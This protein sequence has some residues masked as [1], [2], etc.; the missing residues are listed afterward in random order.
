MPRIVLIKGKLD[1]K[2]IARSFNSLIRSNYEDLVISS[3]FSIS[4]SDIR[5]FACDFPLR[6][7]TWIWKKE[8]KLEVL[9]GSYPT[10]QVV[11]IT[12]EYQV[13]SLQPCIKSEKL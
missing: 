7:F 12:R 9:L 4:R 5:D 13:F 1:P 2:N 6:Q 11:V 10:G 3:I 8:K